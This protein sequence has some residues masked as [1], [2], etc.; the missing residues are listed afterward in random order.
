MKLYKL[1]L[2]ICLIWLW[3]L[4]GAFAQ[5]SD[6]KGLTPLEGVVIPKEQISQPQVINPGAA[7]KDCDE[8]PEM[9]VIPSGSFMMGGDPFDQDT[10]EDQQPQHYVKIQ[11][12]A[13][14]KYE[15]TQ[16]E[17]YKVMGNNPSPAKGR[18]LP[19]HNVSLYEADQFVK[20]LSYISGKKY[21][22]PSE[23]EWEYAARAGSF[24]KYA[25]GN[26]QSE[27]YEYG[28]YQLNSGGKAQPVGLKKSNAFGIY[29]MGGNVSEWVADCAHTSYKD[30]PTDGS[31]WGNSLTKSELGYSCWPIERGGSYK[32]YPNPITFR[33]WIANKNFEPEHRGVRVARELP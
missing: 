8:C 4:Q 7:F 11:S 26:T 32:F 17:W 28:W 5:V 14:G 27:S 6:G 10:K 2:G 3:F 25:G 20:K 31:A 15:V 16:E 1:P 9:V 30:A 22:I 24:A 29:D 12:F 13:L 21:R 18:K 19:V 33:G 23:A